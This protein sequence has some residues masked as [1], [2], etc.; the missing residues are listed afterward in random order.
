MTFSMWDYVVPGVLAPLCIM[1]ILLILAITISRIMEKQTQTGWLRVL[2]VCIWLTVTLGGISV[3][4]EG[5]EYP[6]TAW[7]QANDALHTTIGQVTGISNAPAPPVYGSSLHPAMLVEVDGEEYYALRANVKEGEW[8]KIQWATDARIVYELDKSTSNHTT[9]N[10]TTTEHASE[11]LPLTAT[12]GK[13]MTRV[14]ILLSLSVCIL[15]YPFG[16]RL[17]RVL[18]K[19]DQMFTEGVIPNRYG[20]VY[21][22]LILCVVSGILLGWYLTGFGGAGVILMIAV[23]VMIWVC[24]CKRTVTVKIQENKL[25]YKG[26]RSEQQIDLENIVSVEW[27]RSGIP[28][29]RQL[30]IHLRSRQ[31]IILQQEHYWGLESLY[32]KLQQRL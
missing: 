14:F 19:K 4:A 3:L 25:V 10:M 11:E 12:I 13:W 32:S 7:I 8:V 2:P 20:W 24:I 6:L 5:M 21:S 17:A 30:V 1:I 28:F 23:P 31:R 22:S 29:N 9:T 16:K 26:L 15:Q 27:G 18:V